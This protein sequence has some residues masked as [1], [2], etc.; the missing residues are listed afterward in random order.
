MRERQDLPLSQSNPVNI[1]K[2]RYTAKCS[3]A[4]LKAPF[5]VFTMLPFVEREGFTMLIKT[6]NIEVQEIKISYRM[7]LLMHC[8][9]FR[10]GMWWS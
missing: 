6:L 8:L 2:L 7:V 3:P 9:K 5:L 4:P 1:G 10:K